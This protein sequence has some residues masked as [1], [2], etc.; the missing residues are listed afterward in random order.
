MKSQRFKDTRTGEIVTQ[1]PISEIANF[2]EF[3]GPEKPVCPHCLKAEVSADA[4]VRWD[5][6]AQDWTVSN[7]FDKDRRC[8]NHDGC[9]YG[10]C[11]I[12]EMWV[13]AE[14]PKKSDWLDDHLIIGG[15]SDEQAEQIKDRLRR[16]F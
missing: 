1:V 13:S 2:E 6:E 3:D 5:I 4:A 10:G 15:V 8:E 7:V 12:T 16:E 11:E 9:D 14:E